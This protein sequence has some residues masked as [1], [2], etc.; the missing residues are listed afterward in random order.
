[1]FPFEPL[2]SSSVVK[3]EELSEQSDGHEI[4][5]SPAPQTPLQSHTPAQ[6]FVLVSHTAS[7]VGQA[8]NGSSF[9]AMQ[10]ASNEQVKTVGVEV[11]D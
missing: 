3:S 2:F 11:G 7:L 6:V 8:K 10:S 5:L 1:M 9:G 4:L